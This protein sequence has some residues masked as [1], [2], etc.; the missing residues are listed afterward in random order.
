MVKS[1]PTLPNDLRD[2]LSNWVGLANATVAP[3]L[4]G[5]D[6]LRLTRAAQAVEMMIQKEDVPV[7]AAATV[8]HLLRAMALHWKGGDQHLD[9]HIAVVRA[10]LKGL[11]K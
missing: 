9:Q 2:I 7:T 11:R 8:A 3:Q 5:D 4:D 10:W 6:W 1:A